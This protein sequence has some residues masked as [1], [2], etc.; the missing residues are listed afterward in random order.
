MWFWVRFFLY[1]LISTAAVGGFLLSPYWL[2]GWSAPLIL[3]LGSIDAGLFVGA[4][5]SIADL[6]IVHTLFK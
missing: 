6:V 5:T 4:L 2:N 3:Y 1:C